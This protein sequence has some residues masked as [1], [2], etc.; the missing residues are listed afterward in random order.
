MKLD[1]LVTD[2]T[3]AALA[4]HGSPAVRLV[5]DGPPGGHA[6]FWD[7]ALSRR[8]FLTAAGVGG[9]ALGLGV[10]APQ[11]ALA[12]EG[13]GRHGPKPIPG[14]V[15]INGTLFHVFPPGPG[16]EPATI[17]DFRG[18]VGVA[19][20][21]GMGTGVDTSTGARRRLPF[22]VDNRFMQG[23]FVGVDGKRHHGTFG[24]V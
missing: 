8:G 13:S 11:A 10:V 23:V 15:T 3:G 7:R 17:F 9:A 2:V 1:G 24:F 22:D 20:V 12:G 4:P 18:T 6:H 5:R 14:G 16:A 19:H 21:S